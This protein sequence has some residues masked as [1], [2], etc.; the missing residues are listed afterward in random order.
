MRIWNLGDNGI[1]WEVK[2]W[3]TDYQHHNDTDALIRQRI[4]YAFERAGLD[5]AY[6]T[7]TIYTAK[8]SEESNVFV[9]TADE[10]CERINS[11]PIFAP[12]STEETQRISAS[13]MVRVFSP[14]NR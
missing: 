14:V 5:F 3:T 1:D 10:I 12:L 4:W 6:P 2:Y 8:Q 11:I 13:C 9:E 7:R